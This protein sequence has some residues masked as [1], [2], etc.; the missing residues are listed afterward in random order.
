M[1]D[2]INRVS[3]ADLLWGDDEFQGMSQGNGSQAPDPVLAI[4][5]H[6]KGVSILVTDTEVRV[7]TVLRVA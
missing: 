7:A 2:V 6:W 1:K 5:K 4:T 3:V